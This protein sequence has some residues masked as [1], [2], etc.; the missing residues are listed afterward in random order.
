MGRHLESWIFKHLVNLC[1]KKGIKRI[2]AEYIR[3]NK[4]VLVS[5]L[6]TDY[7]FKKINNRKNTYIINI[8]NINLKNIEIYD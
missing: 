4:N 7:G 2:Q 1:K 8:N 6:L 5:N 3:S